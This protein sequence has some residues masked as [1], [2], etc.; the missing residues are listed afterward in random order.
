M[1][2]D[3]RASHGRLFPCKPCNPHPGVAPQSPNQGD[4]QVE[5]S[6]APFRGRS[7]HE[8]VGRETSCWIAGGAV[9]QLPDSLRKK[10][11]EGTPA[12]HDG[13]PLERFVAVQ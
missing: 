13:A 1:F 9:V 4:P 7:T 6:A 2:Q 12:S 8:L 5:A 11:F 10:T 3:V